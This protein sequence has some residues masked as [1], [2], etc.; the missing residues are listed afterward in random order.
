MLSRIPDQDAVTTEIISAL[1]NRKRFFL[2]FS[3]S[4]TFHAKWQAVPIELIK[5]ASKLLEFLG[6]KFCNALPVT[7]PQGNNWNTSSLHLQSWLKPIGFPQLP[8]MEKSLRFLTPA[9]RHHWKKFSV[10]W[11]TIRTQHAKPW[12][13]SKT[14][15]A[16]GRVI[17]LCY[18]DSSNIQ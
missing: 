14:K 4:N 12:K 1:H 3:K 17:Y 16:Y 11:F 10:N 9:T 15:F 2:S 8:T 6:T 5:H 13:F 7:S 18:H